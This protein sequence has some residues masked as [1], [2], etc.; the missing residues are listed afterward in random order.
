LFLLLLLLLHLQLLVLPNLCLMLLLISS[1]DS[2]LQEIS[3]QPLSRWNMR[4]LLRCLL[5][6]LLMLVKVELHGCLAAYIHG[7]YG[8]QAYN[9]P[10]ALV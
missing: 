3:D 9:T 8:R 4:L 6:L 5:L 1:E 2:W 10:H 7:I